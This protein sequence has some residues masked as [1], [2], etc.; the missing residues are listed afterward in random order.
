MNWGNTSLLEVFNAAA[1]VG[2]QITDIYTREKK[3]ELDTKL[4]EQQMALDLLQNQLAEDYLKIGPDGNAPYQ[5][6]PALYNTHVQKELNTWLNNA[7]KA[8]N[9]SKYYNDQ[10]AR[11]DMAGRVNMGKKIYEA[12]VLAGRQQAVIAY[13]RED[14]LILNDPRKTTPE[15]L[16]ARLA[17]LDAGISNNIF[18]I[19]NAG[20][21]RD[22]IYT[23]TL[24]YALGQ[25]LQETTGADEKLVRE[26]IAADFP[27]D[28]PGKAEL[29]EKAV[30]T[31]KAQIRK[32]NFVLGA[33]DENAY[34]NQ[35]ASMNNA[36]Q[37]KQFDLMRMFQAQAMESYS[38]GIQVKEA[39]LGTNASEYDINDRPKIEGW[40]PYDDALGEQPPGSGSGGSGAQKPPDDYLKGLFYVVLRDIVQGKAKD[41]RGRGI[42]VAQVFSG[43]ADALEY[44]WKAMEEDERNGSELAKKYLNYYKGNKADFYRDT[45]YTVLTDKEAIVKKLYDKDEANLAIWGIREI[46]STLDPILKEGRRLGMSDAEYGQLLSNAVSWVNDQFDETVFGPGVNEQTFKNKIN[47]FKTLLYSQSIPGLRKGWGIFT[48]PINANNEESMKQAIS[49]LQKEVDVLWYE[50]NDENNIKF[51]KPEFQKDLE[52]NF[53]PEEQALLEDRTNKRLRWVGYQEQEGQVSDVIG[54]G[55]YEDSSGVQYKENVI[56][57]RIVVKMRERGADGTLG[58]W[59]PTATRQTQTRPERAPTFT[60]AADRRMAIGEARDTWVPGTTAPT[61]VSQWG[62]N[63]NVMLGALENLSR[64]DRPPANSGITLDYW[65][66]LRDS[67]GT[68]AREIELMKVYGAAS[69]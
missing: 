12:K 44:V 47:G 62:G 54:L 55:I 8:G 25:N 10:L 7:A 26:K 34:R 49:A 5:S 9:N 65:N 48:T 28:M 30:A 19:T 21:E 59:G 53:R 11:L 52:E 56:N 18:D 2:N 57:G 15:K 29:V 14:N 66:R 38:R 40:Y 43:D 67:G 58:A 61:G 63:Q 1:H 64:Q 24:E 13:D 22:R 51:A 37:A 45:V 46:K 68:E 23:T 31:R 36:Q 50:G 41:A 27:N 60:T 20:K 17:N 6:D 32:M 35:I 33:A 16:Q 39:A 3:Y 4:H 69:R 42:S